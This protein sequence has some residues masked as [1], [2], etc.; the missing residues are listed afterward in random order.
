MSPESSTFSSYYD[1][2]QE[3]LKMMAGIDELL[4]GRR[5]FIF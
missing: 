4:T 1:E 3:L 2:V 5:L